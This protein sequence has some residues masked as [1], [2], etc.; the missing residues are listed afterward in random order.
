MTR[1]LVEDVVGDVA[2]KE[3]VAAP[4]ETNNSIE[5]SGNSVAG[6]VFRKLSLIENNILKI[7]RATD[8]LSAMH[9]KGQ[10]FSGMF[11]EMEKQGRQLEQLQ[12]S[13]T[14]IE[15]ILVGDTEDAP[16]IAT[17]EKG[18]VVNFKQPEKQGLFSRIFG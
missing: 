2:W 6:E 13:L 15:K 9:K 4:Q 11:Q 7:S 3:N 16:Q 8:D 14:H 12:E 5:T 17:E 10:T 18:K 1:E